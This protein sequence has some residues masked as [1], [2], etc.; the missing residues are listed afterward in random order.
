[1]N[2]WA[3]AAAFLAGTI[4]LAC[5]FVL[6]ML[7]SFQPPKPRR[8]QCRHHVADWLEENYPSKNRNRRTELLLACERKLSCMSPSELERTAET[9]FG[10][11]VDEIV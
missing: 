8:L 4:A 11:P 5:A 1:M 9:L 7:Y 10:C 2:Y 3:L 6:F